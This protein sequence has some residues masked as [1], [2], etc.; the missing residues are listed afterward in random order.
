[1][2]K[3]RTTNQQMK[4]AA[5]L[6]PCIEVIE[7]AVEGSVMTGSANGSATSPGYE[8]GESMFGSAPAKRANSYS[9]GTASDIEDLINDILTIEQ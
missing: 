8:D 3:E 9:A 7:M 6:P 4:R 1:M 5:Y 2:K